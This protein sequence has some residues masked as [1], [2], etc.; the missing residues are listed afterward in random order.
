MHTELERW[1]HYCKYNLYDILMRNLIKL[2][3]MNFKY[4]FEIIVIIRIKNNLNLH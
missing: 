2:R 1:L 4:K 3:I